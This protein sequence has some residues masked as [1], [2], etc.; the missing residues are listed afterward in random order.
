MRWSIQELFMALSWQWTGWWWSR[1]VTSPKSI[2]RNIET[3]FHWVFT[4]W[5]GESLWSLDNWL[6][7]VIYFRLK[8]F[9]AYDRMSY[10][11]DEGAETEEEW[12][13][14]LNDMAEGFRRNVYDADSNEYHEYC[15]RQMDDGL[16]YNEFEV[17][18]EIWDRMELGYKE[19]QE[20]KD[21]FW[22]WYGHLWD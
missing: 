14:I 1:L 17:P 15:M 19:T 16:S 22:K 18:Q 2:Y 6:D 7:Q 3:I 8:K 21:L 5:T 4:G 11:G 12:Q 20:M 13:K 10:P 9:A